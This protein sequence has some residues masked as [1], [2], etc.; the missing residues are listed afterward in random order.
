MIAITALKV[1]VPSEGESKVEVT[2]DVSGKPI[3][4][5]FPM[6]SLK[7]DD[8]EVVTVGDVRAR[9]VAALKAIVA[10]IDPGV[11]TDA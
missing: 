10:D 1:S 8:P 9:V 11:P 6:T 3:I 4:H 7:I 5:T 2:V